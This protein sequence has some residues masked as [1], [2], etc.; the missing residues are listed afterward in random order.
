[1]MRMGTAKSDKQD[2]LLGR[3]GFEK[4][5]HGMTSSFRRGYDGWIYADHGFNN[6]STITASD[7]SSI[8]LNSGNTYRFRPDGSRV[9]Q[10]TWGQVNP[11]GLAFDARGDL[12]S[13]DCHSSPVY[14]LLR[15]AHYPEFWQT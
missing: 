12:W 3:L 15:G 6:D 8:K 7:G 1:M 9:E 14:M 2:L 11:F 5:T 4:D 13:A 10:F